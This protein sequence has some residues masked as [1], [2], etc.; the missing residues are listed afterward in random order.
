MW[1]CIKMALPPS[2]P[3]TYPSPLKLHLSNTHGMENKFNG[4][5][6]YSKPTK[7]TVL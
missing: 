4:P 1:I 2:T 7:N 3:L 6:I 5:N